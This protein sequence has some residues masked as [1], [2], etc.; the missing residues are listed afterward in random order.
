MVHLVA[1][2]IGAIVIVAG[3]AGFARSIWRSP[4]RHG[5]GHNDAA[6]AQTDPGRYAGS[7][8][9]VDSSGHGAGGTDSG[10]GG[11]P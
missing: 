4:G 6:V 9:H 11:G 1:A 5:G 8:R 2:A 3:L 10:Y 7:H